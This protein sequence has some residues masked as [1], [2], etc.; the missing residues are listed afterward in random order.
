MGVLSTSILSLAIYSLR[1]NRKALDFRARVVSPELGSESVGKIWVCQAQ[2]ADDV[3]PIWGYRR[4]GV[5]KSWE[6][7]QVGIA[8]A[9]NISGVNDGRLY[10]WY[11][12]PHNLTTHVNCVLILPQSR[13]RPSQQAVGTNYEG[14]LIRRR[15]RGTKGSD[16]SYSFGSASW[17]Q[18]S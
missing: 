13:R 17:A 11:G 6:S 10:A 14:K 16:L 7:W 8:W 9:C 1:V 3:D 15:L 5:C 12:K 2:T 18:M 4:V